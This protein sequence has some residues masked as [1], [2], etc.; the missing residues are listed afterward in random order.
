MATTPTV[1]D[2]GALAVQPARVNIFAKPEAHHDQGD[3]E[4]Q[5]PRG[6]FDQA[7]ACQP[8]PSAGASTPG[9]QCVARRWLI[10]LIACLAACSA[11]A[12]VVIIAIAAQQP[13]RSAAAHRATPAVRQP[14]TPQTSHETSPRAARRRSR[15]RRAARKPHRASLARPTEHRG[16]GAPEAGAEHSAPGVASRRPNAP[17]RTAP[18]PTRVAPDAPP[19]FM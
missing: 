4:S 15:H 1:T 5:C 9:A 14:Q 17:L 3:S 2:G 10:R 6:V 8:T 13:G 16:L 11:A 19:E 12:A 7:A 18:A